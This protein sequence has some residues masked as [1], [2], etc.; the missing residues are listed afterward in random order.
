MLLYQYVSLAR[1]NIP[2]ILSIHS[3]TRTSE[4]SYAKIRADVLNRCLNKLT[5]TQ[6]F[7]LGTPSL[8]R[9]EGDF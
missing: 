1:L 3:Y 9:K 2:L 5:P 4:L 8:L 6:G 7:A